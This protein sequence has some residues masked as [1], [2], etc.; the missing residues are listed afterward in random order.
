VSSRT[1]GSNTG[2][3][4][5]FT[6]YTGRERVVCGHG[7]LA[8]ERSVVTEQTLGPAEVEPDPVRELARCLPGEGEAKHLVGPDV[9]VGDHQMTRSAMSSVLPEPAPATTRS[10]S[11]GAH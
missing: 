7:R 4:A 10:G 6:H 2:P 9:G 11:S 3:H 5:V 8:A 1:V